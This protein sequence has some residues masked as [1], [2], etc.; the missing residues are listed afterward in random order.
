MKACG[1]VCS[2]GRSPANP[3]LPKPPHQA[4]GRH[5]YFAV[6]GRASAWFDYSRR[7]YSLRINI[8]LTI[9]EIYKMVKD[10]SI[11]F[12]PLYLSM[13]YLAIISRHPVYMSIERME[14]R[15]GL[16]SKASKFTGWISTNKWVDMQ[17]LTW[18][19]S[20]SSKGKKMSRISKG[21][22]NESRIA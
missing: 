22:K 8:L 20:E 11:Q 18:N 17:I 6:I 5:I 3:Q 1:D 19:L 4:I 15:S 13:K 16:H 14:G 7:M 12:S 2:A 21:R 10:F 9:G